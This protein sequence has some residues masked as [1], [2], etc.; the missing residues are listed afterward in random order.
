MNFGE[1]LISLRKE[2]N[3][4]QDDLAKRLKVSRGAIS[5]W[6]I[7]QRTPDPETLQQLADY[8][9]ASVD[10]LLGRT[11]DPQ[12]SA[13]TRSVM[14]IGN[15]LKE[16]RE[17]KGLT[18]QQLGELVNVSDATI[19]R[20]ERNLREPGIETIKL[21]AKVLDCTSDY[22]LGL[23]SQPRPK[24]PAKEEEEKDDEF[25]FVLAAHNEGEYGREPSPELRAIIKGILKEEL[26]KLKKK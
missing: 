10:Y 13:L 6:E 8:F 16:R 23:S 18:Q 2:L 3:M 9:E 20:Y 22:L 19:N 25:D 12:P 26:D 11:D 21:L 14:E 15:R 17:D 4:T 1:R 24:P 5:M 7:N